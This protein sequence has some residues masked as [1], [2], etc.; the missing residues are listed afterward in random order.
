MAGIATYLSIITL[1][2]VSILHSKDRDRQTGL[3]KLDPTIFAY[4]KCT[5]IAK[6]NTGLK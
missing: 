2:I 4:K 6:T 5:I 1:V 3:K